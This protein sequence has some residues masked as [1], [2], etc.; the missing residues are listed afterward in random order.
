MAGDFTQKLNFQLCLGRWPY[1]TCNFGIGWNQ[2]SDEGMGSSGVNPPGSHPQNFAQMVLPQ[3]RQPQIWMLLIIFSYIFSYFLGIARTT[4]LRPHFP[5]QS[6]WFGCEV[7]RFL[8]LP[9]LYPAVPW[10]LL[11]TQDGLTY[12][13]HNRESRGNLVF[14]L[15][16]FRKPTFAWEAYHKKHQELHVIGSKVMNIWGTKSPNPIYTINTRY[17]VIH[18][19]ILGWLGHSP[20]HPSAM[21]GTN[22]IAWM[23]TGTAFARGFSSW[24]LQTHQDSGDQNLARKGR[25]PWRHLG[26][27][28]GNLR[29]VSDVRNT[30]STCG[31]GWILLS[32][33]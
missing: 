27:C 28:E 12:K 19:T 15:M 24:I 3:K 1:T 11:A 16:P 30:I 7:H 31:L 20:W 5:K 17:F 29:S 2:Q 9:A 6:W 8:V 13:P 33:S 32:I 18:C 25:K 22:V 4:G 23:D 21:A 14:S 10:W 26:S